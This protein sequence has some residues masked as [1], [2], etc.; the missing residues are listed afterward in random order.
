MSPQPLALNMPPSM[1]RLATCTASSFTPRLRTPRTAQLSSRISPSRCADV[2]A[3]GPWDPSWTRPSQISG[4]W[5]VMA[6]S[7]ALSQEAW[8]PL[9]AQPCCIKRSVIG[10]TAFLWTVDCFD[11]ESRMRSWFDFETL[12]ASISRSWTRAKTSCE[13][14]T[15]LRTPNRSGKSSA[16]CSLRSSTSTRRSWTPDFC[17]RGRCTLMS[18]SRCRI[19]APLR[20]S[21]LTT[22]SAASLRT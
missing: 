9:W 20:R 2:L 12:W 8:T 10:S 3:T 5:S 14:S 11:L 18:S 1:T 7:L 13:S 21:N 17:F 19:A 16:A 22:T 4:R 6:L 15:A